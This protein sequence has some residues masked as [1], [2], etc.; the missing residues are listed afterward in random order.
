MLLHEREDGVQL[1]IHSS[2]AGVDLVLQLVMRCRQSIQARILGVWQLVDDGLKGVDLRF[3]HLLERAGRLVAFV[4]CHDAGLLHV[5]AG[6]QVLRCH[7]SCSWFL[8]LGNRWLGLESR[9]ARFLALRC[10][11]VLAVLRA[12]RVLVVVGVH[13]E[14][15]LVRL[16]LSRH[17]HRG[18]TRVTCS[19][20]DRADFEAEARSGLGQRLPGTHR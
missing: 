15:A 17:T 1:G 7:L 5:R 2:E 14:R 6:H 12:F 8:G 18:T 4:S 3:V 9:L 13:S 16:C 10:L 11:D 19:F 20:T